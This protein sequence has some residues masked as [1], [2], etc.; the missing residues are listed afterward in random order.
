MKNIKKVCGHLKAA[1]RGG[2]TCFF[3]DKTPF[4]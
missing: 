3:L 2:M 4:L 1:S